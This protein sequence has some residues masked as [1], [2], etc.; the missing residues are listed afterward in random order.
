MERF[1]ALLRSLSSL[2]ASWIVIEIAGKIV[3]WWLKTLPYD[4]FFALAALV[5][6]FLVLWFSI[7]VELLVK[8]WRH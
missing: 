7:S 1:L 3:Q 2:G 5:V 4:T 6:M 8:A